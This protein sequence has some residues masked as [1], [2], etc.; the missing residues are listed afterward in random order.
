MFSAKIIGCFPLGLYSRRPNNNIDLKSDL[1]LKKKFRVFCGS[2]NFEQEKLASE[3]WIT[4]KIHNA[5]F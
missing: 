5:N 2:E 3:S 4:E 1:N